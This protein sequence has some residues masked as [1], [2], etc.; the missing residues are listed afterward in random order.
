M[1]LHSIRHSHYCD[2][3]NDNGLTV[4]YFK[5]NM[6]FHEWRYKR[7]FLT[8]QPTQII[9]SLYYT[10]RVE[11]PDSW[12]M[13][14]PCLYSTVEAYFN[15]DL[16]SGS[17]IRK[18]LSSLDTIPSHFQPALLLILVVVFQMDFQGYTSWRKGQRSLGHAYISTLNR[19]MAGNYFSPIFTCLKS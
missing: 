11:G 13:L 2:K 17:G 16:I 9:H 19:L 1:Q 10:H 4:A 15:I 6:F 12:H 8:C 7:M 14:L 18:Q 3:F 5:I